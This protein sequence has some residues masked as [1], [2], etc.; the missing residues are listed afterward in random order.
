MT[1]TIFA[2]AGAAAELIASR[3]AL[4]PKSAIVLG[5]G[6]GAFAELLEEK[7]VIPF[8]EIPHFP[9]STVPGHGGKLVLGTVGG[10][11]VAV[12]QGRVHA[13]E[14]YSSDEVV[15]PIRVLGRMGV[16]QLVLTNAAGGINPAFHRGQLVL[17]S[18]HINLSGRNPVVG[19]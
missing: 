5:S 8:A 18:D 6:L 11:P 7:T 10:V 17:I 16:T 13:Y 15:F 2:M 1:D 12:M 19:A 9:R 14:G 3:S 4:R